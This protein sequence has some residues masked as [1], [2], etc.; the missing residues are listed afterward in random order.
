MF[1]NRTQKDL[2]TTQVAKLMGISVTSTQKMIDKGRI[3]AW[4][5]KGGHRRVSF[6]EILSLMSTRKMDL[7]RLESTRQFTK[8]C[9]YTED[10]N[11]LMN[12][13]WALMEYPLPYSFVFAENLEKFE[14]ITNDLAAEVFMI[15][16]VH[17]SIDVMKI[18]SDIDKVYSSCSKAVCVVEFNETEEVCSEIN[19]GNIQYRLIPEK[20]AVELMYLALAIDQDQ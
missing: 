1:R 8:I 20:M 2:T 5:T 14:K 6:R 3:I 4:K 16:G 18:V 9:V 13:K 19:S 15:D 7:S 12:L 11:T 10:Q 17:V